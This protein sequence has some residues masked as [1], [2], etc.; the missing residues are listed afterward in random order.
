MNASLNEMWV[1]YSLKARRW[2]WSLPPRDRIV[3]NFVGFFLVFAMVYMLI[4]TPLRDS[5]EQSILKWQNKQSVLDWIRSNEA[6]VR[7]ASSANKVAGGIN[8]RNG[9]SLLTV[10]NSSAQRSNL[11]LKR[12]E[13]DG[14]DKLRVWLENVSFNNAINW[15]NMLKN[16]FGI[17]VSNISI[18]AH[19]AAG[20]VDVKIVLKG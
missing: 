8:Q 2:Y 14:D 15:L 9:Q 6:T 1:Q 12:F 10:V 5:A 11:A 4:W 18:E 20:V 19:G 16:D 13:P 7:S 17:S 3:V